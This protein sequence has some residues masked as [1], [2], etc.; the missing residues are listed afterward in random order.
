[1]IQIGNH[2]RD[3]D[4]MARLVI[5]EQVHELVDGL[6]A[7]AEAEALARQQQEDTLHRRL[8]G[9]YEDERDRQRHNRFQMAL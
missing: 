1:M 7:Q 5:G 9:F 4:P 2:V 6:N 8:W 3:D